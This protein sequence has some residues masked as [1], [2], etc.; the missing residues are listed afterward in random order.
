[1]KSKVTKVT[2]MDKKDSYGNTSF[3][4]EFEN[5]DKGFYTSK[6]EDQKNF[7]VGTETEYL[8]EKKTGATG[9]EYCKISVPQK[10]FQKF[11]QAKAPV[12]PK[13]QMIS[14]SASYT[15]DLIVAGKVPYEKFDEAFDKLYSKM[16]SK[17]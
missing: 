5:G 3:V 9:K 10:E 12:D 7:V 8:S 11:N 6:N 15:K 2:K 4:I 1:M 14:F 13:I 17:L 16:I